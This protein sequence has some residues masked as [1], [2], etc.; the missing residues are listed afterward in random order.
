MVISLDFMLI[1]F[2]QD[3]ETTNRVSLELKYNVPEIS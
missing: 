3:Q 2:A 1:D